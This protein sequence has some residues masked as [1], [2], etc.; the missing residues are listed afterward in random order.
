MLQILTI[1]LSSFQ[2]GSQFHNHPFQGLVLLFLGTQIIEDAGVLQF[3]VFIPE[4]KG[5]LELLGHLLHVPSQSLRLLR[6]LL[7]LVEQLLV[8]GTDLL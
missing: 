6:P 4:E 1:D 5:V 3:G 2:L 7:S 8:A